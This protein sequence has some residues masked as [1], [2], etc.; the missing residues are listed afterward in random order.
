MKA[1]EDQAEDT[2]FIS[3]FF[4]LDVE[5][6][7]A[8]CQLQ[9]FGQSWD[10]VPMFKGG[11]QDFVIGH[12]GQKLALNAFVVMDNQFAVGTSPHVEL[13]HVGAKIDGIPH[14]FQGV[15]TGFCVIPAMSNNKFRRAH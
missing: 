2:F 12:C 7:A 3:R 11:M 13:H 14:C 15:F 1:I 4:E 6:D 9:Q 8:A 10:A 5:S